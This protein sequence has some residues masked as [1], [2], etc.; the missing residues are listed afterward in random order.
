MLTSNIRILYQESMKS[1]L[2]IMQIY[3]ELCYHICTIT[4]LPLKK[5]YIYNVYITIY[6]ANI[7]ITHVYSY[8]T[9]IHY[10]ALPLVY[11][12]HIY[13]YHI[14]IYMNMSIRLFLLMNNGLFKIT[15][16]QLDARYHC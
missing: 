11:P 16:V 14:Y 4:K 7:Y 1:C 12:S 5:N 2:Y 9:Y 13:I 3:F 6:V 8:I 10:D 15:N